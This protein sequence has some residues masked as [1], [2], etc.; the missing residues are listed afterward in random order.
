MK[1]DRLVVGSLKENCF[2]VSAKDEAL[3]I[4]PGDDADYITS[5]IQRKDLKPICIIAT[6][7]HFDHILAAFEICMNFD[8]PFLMHKDDVFLLG[9][10]KQSARYYT[11]ARDIAPAPEVTRFLE[12]KQIVRL[13]EYNFN[14]IVTPGHTPGSICLYEENESLIFCGDL[15]F[16]NG[17]ARF[18]FAYSNKKDLVRSIH[19]ILT[20]PD[21]T[22]VYPG[23]GNV[24]SVGRQRAYLKD[25][26]A[27]IDIL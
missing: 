14:V 1:V 12:N 2:I 21:K 17:V 10:M 15:I 25:F 16:E 24:T 13:A 4:D 22:K 3:I 18:D 19:K 7:G 11:N 20:L 8:I 5:Y 23:H 9:R 26:L 6:H 27:L